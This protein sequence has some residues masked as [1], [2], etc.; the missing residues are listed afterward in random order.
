MS[1]SSNRPRMLLIAKPRQIMSKLVRMLKLML[2]K[3]SWLSRK[4][5]QSI[6]AKM[7]LTA[8]RCWLISNSLPISENTLH[9]NYVSVWISM[10][11]VKLTYLRVNIRI[12]KS[13]QPNLPISKIVLPQLLIRVRILSWKRLIVKIQASKLPRKSRMTE[14]QVKTKNRRTVTNQCLQNAKAHSI[15]GMILTHLD[16]RARTYQ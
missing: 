14:N 12:N 8:S 2:T 15:R 9:R 13:S 6:W 5:R 10:Q 11:I 16:N 3:R 7:P 4:I 1:N